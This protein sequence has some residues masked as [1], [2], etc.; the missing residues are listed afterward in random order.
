MP[1]T[2]RRLP[3][4]G[5]FHVFNRGACRQA[6]FASDEDRRVFF[7]GLGRV[8]RDRG[9]RLLAYCLMGNHYHLVVE[10]PQDNLVEGMHRL[11]TRF[12]IWFNRAHETTGH[13]FERRF[14]SVPVESQDY[15]EYLLG[16]VAFNPVAAGLCRRAEDW[17]WSSFGSLMRGDPAMVDVARLFELLGARSAD[18]LR[19]YRSCLDMAAKPGGASA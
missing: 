5:T 14:N 6:V 12:A 7:D 11:K 15:L 17:P 4:G 19:A 10:T 13:V 16:Y 18:P 1:R 9:W 3:P 8:I 2:P